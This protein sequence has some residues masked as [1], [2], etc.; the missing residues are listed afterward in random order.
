MDA[1]DG[2]QSRFDNRRDDFLSAEQVCELLGVKRATLYTY[3]SRGW[4]QRVASGRGRR[5]LYLYAD[6]ARLRERR[7]ARAGH[8]AAAAGAL[9]WGEPVIT[10]GVARLSEAGISY[11]GRSVEGL[12]A[13][14]VRFEAVAELLWTGALGEA[15][16]GREGPAETGVPDVQDMIGAVLAAR[17]LDPAPL[18]TGPQRSVER[19]RA[20]VWALCG[21]GGGSIAEAVCRRMGTGAPEAVE[22][23]DRALVLS[24]EHGLNASTFATRVAA[25]TGADLFLAITAGLCAF[26]GPR[27]GR[28]CAGIE[29]ML[30]AVDGPETA[31]RW[32]EGRYRAGEVVPG[33]LHRLYPRGDPRGGPLMADALALGSSRG[34]DTL[35]AVAAVMK[36]SGWRTPTVDFGLV[37]LTEAL[38]WPRGSAMWVFAVG[39]CAGWVAHALEQRESGALLRPRATYASG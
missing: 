27:H 23:V 9:R 16:W 26:S 36:E 31:R 1:P 2:P 35:V 24:A 39:R 5:N 25:S 7:D 15:G 21:G 28:A 20:L 18:I 14:R 33:F 10:T 8:T 37:A 11:R 22:A 32:V 4:I 30:D 6:V 17:A 19:G 38:G 34:V 13:D 3:V 12:L 29:A